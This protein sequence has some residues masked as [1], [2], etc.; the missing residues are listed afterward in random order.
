[1]KAVPYLKGGL[2]G[3]VMDLNVVGEFG[4]GEKGN[5]VVLLEITEDP[6]EL[7][8]LLVNLFGFSVRLWVEGS[9]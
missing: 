9:G 6:K 4:K 1:M 8:N 3:S 2:P 5:P 7:F